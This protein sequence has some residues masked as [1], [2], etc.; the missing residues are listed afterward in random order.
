MQKFYCCQKKNI[1][2]TVR[3]LTKIDSNI[4]MKTKTNIT[5]IICIFGNENFHH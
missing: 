2:W 3:L 1:I 4:N 5:T